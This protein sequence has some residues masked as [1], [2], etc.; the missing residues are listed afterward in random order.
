MKTKFYEFSQNN[1]GGFFDVNDKVCHRV[2]IEAKNEK[3]AISIITPMVEDQS[4]SCPCCGD[5]WSL[6]PT[7]I[8]INEWKKEGYPVG[9]YDFYENPEK[10]WFSMYGN[11]PRLV[12][13]TWNSDKLGVS[14][15]FHGAIYFN[16]IEE[17]CQHL[18]NSYGWTSPDVRIYYTDGTQ[19][20][21]FTQDI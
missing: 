18:A 11:F 10:R 7:E 17:Y 6:Y 5:R 3:E 19:V 8:D 1:S 15:Q 12:E 14:R 16:T 9:V 20:E 13:P 2:V 21:I 4:S